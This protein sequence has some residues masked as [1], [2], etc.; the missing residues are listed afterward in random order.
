MPLTKEQI[1]GLDIAQQRV[2]A[3]GTDPA[4][5]KNL[6][7]AR[8]NFGYGQQQQPQSYGET[9]NQAYDNPQLDTI[10]TKIEESIGR[11]TGLIE[12]QPGFALEERGR[13]LKQDPEYQRLL[14]ERGA[15]TGELHAE[16]FRAEE[17]FQNVFDPIERQK[18]V[19]QSV[20][21]VMGRLGSL[22]TRITGRFGT[23]TEQANTAL[24]YLQSQIQAESG[25]LEGLQEQRSEFTDL[26]K[27]IADKDW[28]AAQKDLNRVKDLEADIILKQTPTYKNLHPSDKTTNPLKFSTAQTTRLL[29]AGFSNIDVDMISTN[30]EEGWTIDEILDASDVTDDQAQTLRNTLSGIT[31]LQQQSIDEETAEAAPFLNKDYFTKL[32]GTGLKDAASAGGF[33]GGGFLGIGTGQK[34][35]DA[36]LDDLMDKVKLYHQS[37]YTDK[38]ILKI[39]Q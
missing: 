8:D 15:T 32:Y 31:P 23:A 36:F 29:G 24:E 5:L 28:D 14:E 3:G 39:M 30:L 1:Q 38:E 35:I 22:N 9:L 37:G 25:T 18:L 12:Q 34:G 7:Y 17:Q 11:H 27:S 13:L 10:D 21:N 6:Q 4:D 19:A 26:L 20:G 2:D 16:P 33:T